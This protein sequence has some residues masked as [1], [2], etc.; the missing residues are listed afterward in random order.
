M[1]TGNLEV[2]DVL[3]H[4][5]IKEINNLLIST[6]MLKMMPTASHPLH[7]DPEKTEALGVSL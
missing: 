3:F 4:K 5:N 6:K 1:N 2:L 7:M